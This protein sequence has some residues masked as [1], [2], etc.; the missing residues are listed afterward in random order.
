MLA[1]KMFKPF[2]Q[3]RNNGLFVYTGCKNKLLFYSLSPAF[4]DT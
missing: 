1:K 4:Y 2:N 3:Y